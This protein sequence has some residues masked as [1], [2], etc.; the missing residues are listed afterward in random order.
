MR[1][2]TDIAPPPLA[3]TYPARNPGQPLDPDWLDSV[4]VD[5]AAIEAEATEIDASCNN[6]GPH[7]AAWLLRAIQCM[8]LTTL[9]GDDTP[10]RV[11]ALCQ[12][13]RAPLP[14]D[15]AAKHGAG[16]LT[17]GAVCVYHA[18]IP[19]ALAALE[20]SGIPVAAVSAGFPAGL[21]SPR[22]RVAEVED[23]VAAGA[24]EIDIVIPRYLALSGNWTA[25]YEDI[26]ALRAA[27]GDAHLKC[28]LSVGELGDLTTVARASLTAMMAG[29]D[30]VKT[31]T[32]KEATNATLPAALTMLHTI[33]AYHQA[34]GHRIGFKPAGGISTVRAALPYM[35]AT[36]ARLG[37][38]WLQ[39]TLFRF[40]ASSLLKDIRA[41]LAAS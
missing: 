13:A 25:L 37:P 30:V 23:S 10:E 14:A 2:F 22:A 17:V 7:H 3:T 11:K 6:A 4:Q 19:T 8:D 40:G 15:L 16:G 28:I 18:M 27:C 20:G 21:S 36:H 33:H 39:P 24:T 38:D 5:D 1:R 29:A 35:A 12:T 41:T 34:T 26:R 31:S 32:G 9:S